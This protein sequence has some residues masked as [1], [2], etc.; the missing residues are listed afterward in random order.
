[1]IQLTSHQM[2]Q[3]LLALPDYPIFVDGIGE[4]VHLAYEPEIGRADKKDVIVIE[5]ITKKR[6]DIQNKK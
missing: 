2:A 5:I 1:M 3:K 6:F 4:D